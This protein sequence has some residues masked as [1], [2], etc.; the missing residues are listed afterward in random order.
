MKELHTTVNIDTANSATT[1]TTN[2]TTNRPQRIARPRTLESLSDFASQRQFISIIIG[3]LVVVFV[4]VVV[5]FKETA[6]W[7]C[8]G[9]WGK[10]WRRRNGRG[11]IVRVDAAVVGH[12]CGG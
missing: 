3:V 5:V 7:P 10:D 4:V 9:G 12:G 8:R 11:V 2:R 6:F 1:T